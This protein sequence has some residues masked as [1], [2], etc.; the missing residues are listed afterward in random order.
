[1]ADW[2]SFIRQVQ[3]EIDRMD[4][5]GCT[6]P[7]FRGHVDSAYPLKPSLYRVRSNIDNPSDLIGNLHDDF[8]T[9][10]GPL[11][12]KN[13]NPW[14]I[15]FQMRHAGLPTPLL[16]WTE[17][18][19]AA[20][21]FAVHGFEKKQKARKEK[22]LKPCIW[23]MNPYQLNKNYYNGEEIHLVD[24]LPFT[25]RDILDANHKKI[26]EYIRGPIAVLTHRDHPRIFAQKSVFTLHIRNYPAIEKMC[27]SCVKKID[28]PLNTINDAEKFLFQAGINEYTLF[29]DLDGLG[30]WLTEWYKIE[31]RDR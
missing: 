6:S 23:I 17:N 3:E 18:F 24:D 22:K 21:Y 8:T 28:I 14:E 12:I 2:N 5:E 26:E 7:F 4:K 1:M 11:N 25:C 15:L 27:R 31:K 10:C 19:A 30:R 13:E 16:D 20:V 9:N 29:P